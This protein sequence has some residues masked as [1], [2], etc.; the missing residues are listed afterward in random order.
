MH[1][2]RIATSSCRMLHGE[3]YGSLEHYH[4]PFLPSHHVHQLRQRRLSGDVWTPIIC[5]LHCTRMLTSEGHRKVISGK[6]QAAQSST[7][8]NSCSMRFTGVFVTFLGCALMI[9]RPLEGSQPTR[10]HFWKSQ[11]KNCDSYRFRRDD[12]LV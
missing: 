7:D 3:P 1:D 5:D 6:W 9:A 12:C 10:A 8:G 2:A 11:R 4:T